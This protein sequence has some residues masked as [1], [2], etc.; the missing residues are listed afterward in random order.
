MTRLQVSHQRVPSRRAKAKA[1]ATSE[2]PDSGRNGLI[3]HRS[4][5]PQSQTAGPGDGRSRR[6]R[7]RR[8][9]VNDG[10]NVRIRGRGGG[11]GGGGDG[12][13]GGRAG[14]SEEN[15]QGEDAATNDGDVR[16]V[17]ALRDDDVVGGAVVGVEVGVG[18]GVTR[19][20]CA[21]KSS[22]LVTRRRPSSL[23]AASGVGSCRSWES[24]H[25]YATLSHGEKVE[26][27]SVAVPRG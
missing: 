3:V 27:E 12:E 13:D 5:G 7:R 26:V 24:V 21:T 20:C 18:V 22:S 15:S 1:E 17:T 6:R 16:A 19:G 10:D 14:D 23:S 8:G 11:G 4:D 9:D 2:R 25:H